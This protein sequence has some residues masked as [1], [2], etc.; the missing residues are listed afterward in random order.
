MISFPHFT[1]TRSKLRSAPV[2]S[3]SKGT[4]TLPEA[5]E[6]G[7]RVLF[8]FPIITGRV[9]P[10]L[11]L[12]VDCEAVKSFSQALFAFRSNEEDPLSAPEQCHK[13]AQGGAHSFRRQD[14]LFSFFSQ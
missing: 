9:F 3:F 12:F 8:D 10:C 1:L 5:L 7:P 11:K 6:C 14:V 4:K 13:M 2:V